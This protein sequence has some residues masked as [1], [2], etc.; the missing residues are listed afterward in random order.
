MFA[1]QLSL[2]LRSNSRLKCDP[3]TGSQTVRPSL[4]HPLHPFLNALPR[5]CALCRK[6]LK[7]AQIMRIL[8]LEIPPTSANWTSNPACFDKEIQTRLNVQ[9]TRC[10][11]TIR[12]CI[13]PIPT[14]FPSLRLFMYSRALPSRC[15]RLLYV[16]SDVQSSSMV[17]FAEAVLLRAQRRK[18]DVHVLPT[19]SPRW[20]KRCKAPSLSQTTLSQCVAA[21]QDFSLRPSNAAQSVRRQGHCP[22][23]P[24][25]SSLN[26]LRAPRRPPPTRPCTPPTSCVSRNTRNLGKRRFSA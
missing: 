6:N 10:V 3:Y 25:N 18:S 26:S 23:L 14:P 11:N 9:R 5:S 24:I 19:R 4:I 15:V 17:S 21:P 2:L 12:V 1:I 22:P 8:S 13:T 16:S 20:T 7:T